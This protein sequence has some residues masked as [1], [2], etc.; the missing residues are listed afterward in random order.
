MAV[1]TVY[2]IKL[3]YIVE[4]RATRGMRDMERHARRASDSADRLRSFLKRAGAAAVGF[5]GVRA[6]G[7]ALLG[8]NANMEQA[9]IRTAG[10]LKMNLGGTFNQ[11]LKVAGGLVGELQERAKASTAT[12]S[13][14]VGFMSEVVGP[15]TQAGLRVKDLSKFTANA[16]IA[17]KAF[18]DEQ[19]AVF[20]IQ[21]LIAGTVGIRD[22][23]AIKLIRL[24]GLELEAFRKIKSEAERLA[25]IQKALAAPEIAE[26]AAAQEKSF[27]GVISTFR[28]NLE[29]TLGKVGIPLFKAMTA[30]VQKWNEWLTKNQDAVTSFAKDLGSALKDVFLMMK[31]VAKF[32]A[33]HGDLLLKIAEAMIVMKLGRM[34]GQVLAGGIGRAGRAARGVGTMA[35]EKNFDRAG[36]RA[37]S[38]GGKLLNVADAVGTFVPALGLGTLVLKEMW[39]WWQGTAAKR[40]EQA[41]ELADVQKVTDPIRT[42][43]KAIGGV[44]EMPEMKR[45]WRFVQA[46]GAREMAL[47]ELREKQR[48]RE[49][50]GL[51]AGIITEKQIRR[52]TMEVESK[53]N[54]QYNNV[55]KALEAHE[56]DIL[57]MGIRYNLLSHDLESF[58]GDVAGDVKAWTEQFG[59]SSEALR[60]WETLSLAVQDLASRTTKVDLAKMYE[61]MHKPKE[62]ATEAIEAIQRLG[63]DGLPPTKINVTI[64]RIEVQSEDPDRF[65]IGMTQAIQDAVRNPAQAIDSFREG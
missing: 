21:Q 4:D 13:E 27:D 18:G 54:A 19:T 65:V 44:G 50:R 22:R 24:A 15:A 45:R 1:S 20:D 2:D 52:E 58:Q 48:W 11:Q 35:L 6:A 36:V 3:R 41:R 40:A 28:D 32:F 42:S 30:E 55:R 17:A 12:T 8:F 43:L 62:T 57:S 46:G 23:F 56:R 38:L 7:R 33:R 16:V 31:G 61:E 5:L 25:V 9:R 59:E 26:M 63:K 29:I 53:V 49:Q 34:A 60:A 10:L 64:Q 47:Q 51:G 39:D 37:A 14:M